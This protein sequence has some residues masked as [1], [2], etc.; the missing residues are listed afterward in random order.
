MS[1]EQSKAGTKEKKKSQSPHQN[2][3]L[4]NIISLYLIRDGKSTMKLN[5]Q[6]IKWT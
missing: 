3:I 5:K 1:L 4:I 2:T 6:K